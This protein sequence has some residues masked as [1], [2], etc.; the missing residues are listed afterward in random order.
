[1]LDDWCMSQRKLKKLIYM[2]TWGRNLLRDAACVH[3]TARAELDQASA[4]FDQTKGEVIPLPFDLGE[5]RD[6]PA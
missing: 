3:C 5:Y 4:W 1:M 6:L 2:N